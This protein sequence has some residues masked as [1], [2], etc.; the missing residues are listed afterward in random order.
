MV[1]ADSEALV[2]AE[3]EASEAEV[4]SGDGRRGMENEK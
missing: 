3:A 1:V 2:V 4:Q